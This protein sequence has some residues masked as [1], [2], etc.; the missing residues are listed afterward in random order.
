MDRSEFEI[1]TVNDLN[2]AADLLRDS[3]FTKE[4]VHYNHANRE[5]TLS[6]WT[7]D[8][9]MSVKLRDRSWRPVN[10]TP[11]RRCEILF[12]TVILVQYVEAHPASSFTLGGFRY[13]H[14]QKV[15]IDSYEGLTIDLSVTRLVGIVKVSDE[16]DWKDPVRAK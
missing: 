12:G 10:V 1:I 8:D 4:R 3:A 2:R 11:R 6:V 9:E 5:L 16:I 13:K 7:P 14:C 15:L